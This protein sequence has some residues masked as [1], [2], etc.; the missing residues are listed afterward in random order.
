MTLTDQVNLAHPI[1]G[2]MD[3]TD[4]GFALL[5]PSILTGPL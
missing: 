1:F 3:L 5:M 4:V 2:R